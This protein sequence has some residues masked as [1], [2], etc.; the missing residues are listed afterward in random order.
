MEAWPWV[1]GRLVILG[2]W[3]EGNRRGPSSPEGVGGVWKVQVVIILWVQFFH[4]I[5]RDAICWDG[6]ALGLGGWGA[7]RGC[8]DGSTSWAEWEW[9]PTQRTSK[10][11][12]YVHADPASLRAV[13]HGRILCFLQQH[14]AWAEEG[15]GGAW[16][17]LGLAFP[18]KMTLKTDACKRMFQVVNCA[19]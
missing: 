3:G 14:S 15:E 4:K 9:R 11:P 6:R 7:W 19:A 18:R 2:D 17:S 1:G 8:G 5:G 12:W 16:D 10:I 13:V